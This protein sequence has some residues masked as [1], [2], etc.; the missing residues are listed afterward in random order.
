[1]VPSAIA[2]TSWKPNEAP[3]WAERHGLRP[4]A[5]DAFRAGLLLVDANGLRLGG[6]LAAPGKRG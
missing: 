1:M 4:A 3:A 2:H 5:E 6:Q